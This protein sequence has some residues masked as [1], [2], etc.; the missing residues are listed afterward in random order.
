MTRAHLRDIINNIE[1][2]RI[3]YDYNMHVIV[4]V[5]MVVYIAMHAIYT[6]DN[7]H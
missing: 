2:D 5:C 7:I 4:F 1:V 6:G 3:Y